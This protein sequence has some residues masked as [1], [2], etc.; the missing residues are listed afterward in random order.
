MEE[1][2]K[3]CEKA[4]ELLKIKSINK[5]HSSLQELHE[6]WKDIGPVKRGLREEIWEKFQ[7]ISKVINKKHNDYYHLLNIF[8]GLVLWIYRYLLLLDIVDVRVGRR[9][10]AARSLTLWR[11]W[12]RP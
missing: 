4:N 2:I 12:T 8:L 7:T 1:K 3:I 5:M 6:H 10:Q 9:R 11:G